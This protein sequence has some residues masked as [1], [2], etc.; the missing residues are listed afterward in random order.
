MLAILWAVLVIL[1][2]IWL[3]AL[4]AD[5]TPGFFPLLFAIAAIWLLGSLIWGRLRR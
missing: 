1:G 2:A 5:V 3:L 4:V